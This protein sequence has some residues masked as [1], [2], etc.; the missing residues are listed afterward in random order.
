MHQ[1]EGRVWCF[2]S[3]LRASNWGGDAWVVVSRA[4]NGGTHQERDRLAVGSPVERAKTCL[5]VPP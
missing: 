4:A 5:P 3:G 2:F 1:D